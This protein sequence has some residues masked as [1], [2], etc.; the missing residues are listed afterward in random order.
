MSQEDKIKLMLI[1]EAI[2]LQNQINELRKTIYRKQRT[3]RAERAERAATRSATKF[4][5]NN[6]EYCFNIPN[7]VGTGKMY[8]LN[9][10]I[11]LDTN[12]KHRK[13]PYPTRGIYPKEEPN[14]M[15]IMNSFTKAIERNA[16]DIDYL[17]PLYNTSPLIEMTADE[18]AETI[19]FCEQEISQEKLEHSIMYALPELNLEEAKHF[20]TIV[21][22]MKI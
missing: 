13:Q 1:N 18:V 3:E 12:K 6:N 21:D 10:K 20:L 14:S 9:H 4:S 8:I 5:I 15:I 11:V 2:E 19:R 16:P 22:W 7:Q 17:L